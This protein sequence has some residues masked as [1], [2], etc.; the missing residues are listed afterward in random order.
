MRARAF[1]YVCAGI[2]CLALAYH[3]GAKSAK[4]QSGITI[5]GPGLIQ[6]GGAIEAT[7]CVG[8]ILY[9]SG[10]PAMAPPVPGSAPIV[11]TATLANSPYGVMLA[12]GDIYV[13]QSPGGWTLFGNLLGAAPTSA[14]PETMS[15][16]KTR[17]R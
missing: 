8:R 12:N 9:I 14:T 4:A 13:F 6:H 10:T 11:A 15:Q 2:L 17:Y 5:E 3:L 7:G 1:F 16:L